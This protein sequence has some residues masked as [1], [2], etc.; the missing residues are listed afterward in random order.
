MPTLNESETIG[1]LIR[2]LLEYNP[3]VIIIIDD[4]SMDGTVEIIRELQQE[5]E[6]VKLLERGRRLGL[7]SAIVNGFKAALE[8]KPEPVLV[9]TLDADGSHD[10]R[11]LPQLIKLCNRDSLVIGSRYAF[12]GE[13]HGWGLTRRLASR[14][15]NLLAKVFVDLPVI[16]ATSGYRC[17]GVEVIKDILPELKSEGYDIQVEALALAYLKGYEISETPIIFHDR[18]SGESKLASGQFWVYLKRVA[19]LFACI[20]PRFR[21][22][23]F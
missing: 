10:P 16:D 21:K 1:D 17:Y 23:I 7:G 19:S 3:M 11:E 13:I 2:T 15:A 12:G 9:V 22:S 6:R 20:L 18:K 8:F 4:G 5:S 14:G